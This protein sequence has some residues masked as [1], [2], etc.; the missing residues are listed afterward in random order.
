MKR[1]LASFVVDRRRGVFVLML[2][3]AAVSAFLLTKVEINEDL[4][5]YLP[6]KSAMK[7]GIDIM[8]EEFPETQS[9]QTVRVMFDRL[10][11]EEKEDIRARLLSIPN[12]TDVAWQADDPD[13]NRD[14]H[15]LFV[16]STGAGYKSAEMKA[17]KKALDHLLHLFTVFFSVKHNNSLIIELII[18]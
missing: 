4:T 1:K 12:V 14:D 10:K 13:Y 17:I 7:Q 8:A 11:P 9:S 6:D 2:L 18:T 3:I 16:V 15:T 5:R